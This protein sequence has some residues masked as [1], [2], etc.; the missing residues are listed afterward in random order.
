MWPVDPVLMQRH[1][2]YN[3]ATSI[4]HFHLC[5]RA[6]YSDLQSSPTSVKHMEDT[7]TSVQVEQA[8]AEAFSGH[9]LTF[10]N[11]GVLTLLISLGHRAGL[12]EV[13]A[14][15]SA[16][17]STELAKAAK[18]PELYDRKCFQNMF[19]G[20]IF[21]P[22]EDSQPTAAAAAGEKRSIN[23]VRKTFASDVLFV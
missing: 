6:K 18:L 1:G 5:A 21:V 10:L 9:I 7:A 22:D 16:T 8:N 17:T 23:G 3:Q 4:S 19:V 12:C 2:S 20:S 13:M 15:M 14:T 11:H